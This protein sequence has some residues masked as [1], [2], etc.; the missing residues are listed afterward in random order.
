MLATFLDFIDGRSEDGRPSHSK[1]AAFTSW[2]FGLAWFCYFATHGHTEGFL[3]GW[4]SLT[5]AV[6]YGI[7]GL[8]TWLSQSSKP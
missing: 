1:L 5:F 4:G 8:S 6:P 3:L 7:K 2:L